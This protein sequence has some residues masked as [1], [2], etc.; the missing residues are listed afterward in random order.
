LFFNLGLI[1]IASFVFFLEVNHWLLITPFTIKVTLDFLLLNS[2]LAV[3]GKQK[4]LL[5]YIPLQVIYP[6]YITFAFLLSLIKP[7]KWK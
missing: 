7:I 3:I 4:L 1:V 6:F 5:V 2:Y